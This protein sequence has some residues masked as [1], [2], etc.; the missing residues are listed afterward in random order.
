[1]L[2]DRIRELRLSH[3]YTQEDLAEKLKISKSTIGM[4]E[5]NRRSPDIETL[6]EIAK[7]FKVSTDYLLDY[8]LVNSTTSKPF[9]CS[10]KDLALIELFHKISNEDFKSA[11]E[12]ENTLKEF[13]PHISILLPEE[14]ELIDYYNELS[15]KNKRWI[16]G[17]IVDLIK[18]EE[19]SQIIQKAQ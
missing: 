3:N 10:K 19:K 1:M 17:Q 13:F 12:N 14:H 15:L 7:I 11:K 2:G 16:M 9:V 6:V 5:Q 8:A 4:Y 18:T